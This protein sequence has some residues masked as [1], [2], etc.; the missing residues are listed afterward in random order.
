MFNQT[1]NPNIF[2]K[3]QLRIFPNYIFITILLFISLFFLQNTEAEEENFSSTITINS[4]WYTNNDSLFV[5]NVTGKNI[6]EIEFYYSYEKYEE[7]HSN[8]SFYQ[9]ISVTEENQTG[10]F[11][12]NFPKGFGFYFLES[13]AINSSGE[14]EFGCHMCN[15][16]G[17]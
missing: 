17:D 11:S 2:F 9:N 14:S 5:W 4:E 1:L 3:Y 8:W 16:S 12:F 15:W 13:N 7:N 6:T 10:V